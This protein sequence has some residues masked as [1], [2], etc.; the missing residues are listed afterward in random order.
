VIRASRADIG[1]ISRV[2]ADAFHDLAV[3][4][5]LIPNPAAR[6]VIF[7][8]Y[9]RLYVEHAITAGI[10]HTTPGHTAAA[11]WVPVGG[12]GP[13]LPD[14]Y[15]PRLAAATGRWLGRFQAFDLALDRHPAD[16]PHHHLAILAVRPDRQGR[17]IGTALL[18][19]HHAVL[20]R[21]D[22][23]AYLE[24]SGPTPAASTCS[25]ATFSGLTRRSLS[26]RRT[27]D[28][29]DVART[30]AKARRRKVPG[31]MINTCH[32]PRKR[33]TQTAS[34]SYRDILERYAV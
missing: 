8:R 30:A 25:T 29:A 26:G 14:N 20:D 16:L 9:F 7:P 22:M 34:Q 24:A 27:G 2:I 1:V 31:G 13:Q 4:R 23:P 33:H 18:N 32:R 5:W 11:L 10:V 17:G 19:A 21:D 15:G 12:E 6:R 28:V 3:S